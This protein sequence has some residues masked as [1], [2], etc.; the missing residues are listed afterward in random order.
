M[1]SHRLIIALPRKDHSRLI[2]LFPAGQTPHFLYL[3]IDFFKR[4]RLERELGAGFIRMDISALHDR[5]A[6]EIRSDHIKWID[7]LNRRYGQDVEWWFTRTASRNSY[8]SNLFQYS[9][10]LETLE[11]IWN[12]AD[13][14]P[15]LIFVESLGLATAIR[16]WAARRGIATQVIPANTEKYYLLSNYFT[17]LIRFGYFIC[18][19]ILR[20]IA[21][22][23]SKKKFGGKAVPHGKLA[24][25]DTFV[26]DISLDDH[27]VFHDIYLPYL[28]EYLEKNGFQVLIHPVLFGFSFNY[29]SIYKRMRQSG[30]FFII[31]EDYLH[32]SD[33]LSL[34]GYPFRTW[35]RKIT[36]EPFRNFDLSGIINEDEVKGL[37]DSSSLLAGLIYRLFFRLGRTGM[38]PQRVISW[39][40]NQV[41]DKALMAAARQAFPQTRL[42]GAQ[43]CLYAYN[44]L[45]PFPVQSEVEAGIVPHLLLGMSEHLCK[46]AQTFTQD[47]PCR[48][49]AALRYAYIF[50]ERQKVMAAKRGSTVLVLL[51][52][53]LPEAAELL[54]ILLM[55]L[56]RLQEDARVLIKCHPNYTPRDLKRAVGEQHWS[57]RFEIYQGILADAIRGAAV[58]ISSTSGTIVEAAA[59]GI[60]VIFVGRQNAL[61][62]N[63]LEGVETELIMECFTEKELMAAINKCF[64]LNIQAVEQYKALGE[65]I[66]KLFFLPVT[67]DTMRPFLGDVSNNIVS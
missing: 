22:Y 66:I 41:I 14:K 42:V 3:G 1:P 63:V 36:A 27:G 31:P 67:D 55:G 4:Q 2:R 37:G 19:L 33:Y 17:S 53:D 30:T 35:R 34:L 40:E 24:I 28:Y 39:Y 10:Y 13:A 48:P 43:I 16:D 52:H 47:L 38:R 26:H 57:E 12:D 29:F 15:E 21:A 58:V 7:Q 56:N 51:P 8:F 64:N 65:R 60:P 49:A 18:I 6:R 11:R 50:G 54:E 5:V 44:L 32:L 25:V 62:N 23:I 9:C 46:F 59:L 20:Q 61:N 45:F